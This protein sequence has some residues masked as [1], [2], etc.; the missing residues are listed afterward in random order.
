MLV[1]IEKVSIKKKYKKFSMAPKKTTISKRPRASSSTEYDHSQSLSADA[2][3][4]FHASVT[5]RSGIKERG[6]ELDGE[7]AR[8]EGF[9]KT[10]QDCEWQLFCQHPKAI[11]MTV[12]REFFANAPEGPTGHK[13]FVRGKEV[14]YDSAT[15]N[16]LLRLQYNPVGPNEM[17]ILLNDDANMI[18]VT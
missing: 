12:V 18:E 8:I 4:R 13:V 5:K 11:A 9:Y 10:I 1:L 15:I 17:D 14:K 6:F 2:E 3:A 7:N 16:N